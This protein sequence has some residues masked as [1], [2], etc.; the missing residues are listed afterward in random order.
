MEYGE[1]WIGEGGLLST[2]L[3]HNQKQRRQHRERIHEAGYWQSSYGLSPFLTSQCVF[4]LRVQSDA[5]RVFPLPSIVKTL[6]EPS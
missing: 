1:R 4:H 5:I 2:V 3:L 6:L